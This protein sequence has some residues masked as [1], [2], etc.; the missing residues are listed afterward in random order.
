MTWFKTRYIKRHK[1]KLV[2][3]FWAFAAL[4]WAIIYFGEYLAAV[5]DSPESVR[6]WVLD[7]G[8]AAPLAFFGLQVVQVLLAPLNDFVI[9]LAGGFLFGPW[10]GF[11]LNYA[12]WILGAAVVFL[13]SRTVG[14][15]FV[16]LFV[17]EERLA[18][19]DRLLSRG[20][21]V[22][23]ALFLLPGPPDD[24]LVYLAGLSR[25]ISFRT[26]LWMVVVSKIP[27]KLVTSFMGS[28]V[29][30]LSVSSLSVF[31]Y[32]VFIVGS[33]LVVVWQRSELRE[34]LSR[35]RDRENLSE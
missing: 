17:R 7:F 23:F 12:G 30:R 26:F 22:L 6:A 3:Y 24:L 32:V 8:R 14:V 29:A 11:A 9:N 15:R 21:Y 25:S 19:Y 18:Q 10:L 34:L 35:K 4:V 27:G 33:L 13:L 20:R 16:R 28:D 31:L 1:I 2:V 5:F